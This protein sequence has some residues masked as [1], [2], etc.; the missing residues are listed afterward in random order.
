MKVIPAIDLRGGRCVRL[1]HGDFD[2]ETHYSDAPADV[3]RNF[4]GMG[5]DYL[6]VVDLDGARDGSQKNAAS[7]VEIAATPM[8]IQIGGGVRE[9]STVSRWLA[10]GAARVVVGS[11]AVTEPD[12]VKAWLREFSPDRIVLA[13]DVKLV[14][15]TPL[16]ATHGWTQTSDLDL[17][18]CIDT[19][20]DVG[21]HHVLCTDVSRDGALSGPNVELYGEIKA[22]YPS[23]ELQASGGVSG[24]QDLD[25]LAG[26]GADSAITGRALLDGRIT[27]EEIA[28]FRQNG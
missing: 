11:L 17:Y 20:L 15:G 22:R 4:S 7:V 21:L 3:A 25:A 14:D 27:A 12:T 5:F 18:A 16:L 28:S 19:Y 24:I 1:L 10:A 26:A 23:I 9:A 8:T 13:L 6:H 2:R